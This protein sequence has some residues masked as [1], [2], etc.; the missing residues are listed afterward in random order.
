[1]LW[2]AFLTLLVAGPWL[3]SGYLFGTDWPG[4]RRFD[5]PTEASSSA[6]L[7]LT[8]ALLSQLVS[9]EV[10]GKF[11]VFGLLFAAAF[12][13][14]QALP[15]GGF[16]ARA[17]AST[18]YLIN[19][20]V[21]DRMHYGQ[22][23]LLAGYAVLPWVMARLRALF[24]TPGR[25]NVLL[26]TIGLWLLGTLSLHL[27]VVAVALAGALLITHTFAQQDKSLYVRRIG[28]AVALTLGL[29]L[30]ASAYWVIPVLQGR[31]PE[32]IT[33][34]MIGQGDLRAYA[35]VPDQ[36]LGLL[37]NL[38]GLYG[39]WA[40]ATGRFTSM[41]YFVPFWSAILALLLLIATIG[42]CT[43]FRQHR[44][45]LAPW[46]AGLIIAGAAA[47]LLEMGVSAPIT[48]GLV[49]WLD[50]HVP[51]YLG[52]RDA[53][54]WAALLAFVYSQLFG[55]GA[56]AILEGIRDI[57][58]GAL[59]NAWAEGVGAA[60]LLALPL[61][62]GNGLLF[63]SHGEIRPSQYPQGWYAADG[64]LLADHQS[65]RVLF[66]PWHEYMAYSFVRNQN[67]VIASPAPAFFSRPV[68]VSADPEVPGISPPANGDQIAISDLVK[69]GYRGPWAEVLAAHNIKYVLL[70][71]ELDWRLYLY[72]DSEPDLV[73]IQ[74]F[75]SIVLYRNTL[76]S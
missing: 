43:T 69:S 75:G 66:L 65:A 52:M 67:Y 31:G 56:V 30:L 22:L 17:G 37:P 34:A 8:L 35:A 71:R 19:P 48:S 76:V 51:L 68:L 15:S 6:P 28:P 10:T 73:K 47:L 29:T 36:K 50:V 21:Y 61:Y 11:L 58:K 74:D 9:G 70:A 40:E 55:L 38:L 60:M 54:K 27:I 72:L 63:G 33:L 25:T 12:T 59:T 24:L 13:A 53:G 26:A 1:M 57:F 64:A 2:S 42:A 32:G 3:A 18:I 14:Y 23:F 46:T 5:F 39:F 62:Y 44:D 4:P 20:F 16:I 41:K 45:R 49:K 7:R